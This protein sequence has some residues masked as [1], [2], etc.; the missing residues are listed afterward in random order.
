M[1]Y[2]VNEIARRNLELNDIPCFAKIQ[3]MAAANHAGSIELL[4]GP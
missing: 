3:L 2:Q 1:P 4:R